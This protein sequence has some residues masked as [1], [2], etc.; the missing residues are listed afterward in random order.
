[1]GCSNAGVY[2]VLNNVFVAKGSG[3]IMSYFVFAILMVMPA[4][5]ICKYETYTK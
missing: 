3:F 2:T 1:M 5:F 4:R